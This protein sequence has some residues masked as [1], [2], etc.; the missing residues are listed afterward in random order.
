HHNLFQDVYE[1]AGQ[2]RTVSLTKGATLF[3]RPPYIEPE[4][5][6]QFDILRGRDFFKNK[7]PAEYA[8]LAGEHVVELNVIH[9]FREGN[10]RT[11][12]IYLEY[13]SQNAGHVFDRALVTRDKWIEASI[14]GCFE[15]PQE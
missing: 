8:A 11:L 5:E 14:R 1:W 6:R 7:E 9:P 4:M 15:G 2:I 12:Q 10:G 13:L 3:C